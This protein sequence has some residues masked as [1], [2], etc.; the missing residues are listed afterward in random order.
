MI[1]LFAAIVCAWGL[2]ACTGNSSSEQSS[3]SSAG[4]TAAGSPSTDPKLPS[5]IRVSA[6][7]DENPTELQRKYK[8]LVH[9]LKESLGAEVK[10]IPVTDYGAAVQALAAGKVD[11]A[12]LGAFTHVQARNMADVEPLCMREVDRNF[13]SVFVTAADSGI[14]KVEDLRGKTFAFGSK[15]STSGH[16]MPRHFIT[17][18]FQ[19][20]PDRDFDG[21]PVF[22][23]SHDATIR[24]VESGRVAAGAANMLVWE[25]LVREKKVDTDKIRV[26][27]T[28]PGYVDY[29]WT[30]RKAL[31]AEVRQKFANAFLALDAGKEADAQVLGLQDAKKFVKASPGDFDAVE[32][33]ALSTGLLKPGK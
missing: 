21:S 20:D 27:W 30:A 11:F 9:F 15:S 22:S 8:P 25:R 33:V 24:M 5:V 10:Y 3:S 13:K 19:L 16:L 2:T 7:P 18:E 4:S 23:G 28:T 12:W 29:V 14:E 6:I 31:P 32:K 26:F 1:R 17:T